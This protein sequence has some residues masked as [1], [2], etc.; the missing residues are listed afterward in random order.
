MPIYGNWNQYDG[1]GGG[2][3]GMTRISLAVNK[4]KSLATR[5]GRKWESEHYSRARP[6][7]RTVEQQ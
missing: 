3:M 4:N 7:V 2:E 6:T 5:M 1:N